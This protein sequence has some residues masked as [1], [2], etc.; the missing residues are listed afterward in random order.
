MDDVTTNDFRHVIDY[1]HNSDWNPTVGDIDRYPEK[2][3]PGYSYSRPQSPRSGRRQRNLD[4]RFNWP[5]QADITSNYSRQDQLQTNLLAHPCNPATSPIKQM[6]TQSGGIWHIFPL[7]P[8]LL[9]LPWIGRNAMITDVRDTSSRKLWS[10]DRWQR[11][12][13]RYLRQGARIGRKMFT[14]D[15]LNM[16]DG[17][18]V[19][20]AFGVEVHLRAYDEFIYRNMQR[21]KSERNYTKTEFCKLWEELK[22]KKTKITGQGRERTSLTSAEF[23]HH[24][25]SQAEA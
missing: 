21:D 18:I 9:G 25:M 5:S 19:F 11:S 6:C 15:G 1:F 22:V 3:T 17:L 23:H 14:V 16:I 10:A 4:L 2:N 24:M 20:S 13:A 12:Y 7:G 8:L